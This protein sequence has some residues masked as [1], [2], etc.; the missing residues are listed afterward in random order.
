[1]AEG[2]IPA[3]QARACCPGIVELDQYFR[4]RADLEDVAYD[5]SP[6]FLQGPFDGGVRVF[7][8][9]RITQTAVVCDHRN[10]AALIAWRARRH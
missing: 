5:L 7:F 1:M 6:E 3:A 10:P 9:V 4:F 2:T 8:G